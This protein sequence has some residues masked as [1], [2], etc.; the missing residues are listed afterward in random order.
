MVGTE[1]RD[2]AG[3]PDKKAA[4]A[5]QHECIERKLILLT[6]GSWD[7]TIR[8]IPPLVVTKEQVDEAMNIFE[9][10]LAAALN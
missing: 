2:A 7:N 8:W 4:K 5:V 1:F 9:S 10:S 3:K 6:A